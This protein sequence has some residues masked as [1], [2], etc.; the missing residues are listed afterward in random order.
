MFKSHSGKTIHTLFISDL[1]SGTFT[2]LEPTLPG[3]QPL[4]L[5]V[6]PQPLLCPLQRFFSQ[7]RNWRLLQFSRCCHI[8]QHCSTLSVKALETNL[9]SW[10]KCESSFN[11]YRS[12]YYMI[13]SFPTPSTTEMM[14]NPISKID[15]WVSVFA[16]YLRMPEESDI[17]TT[18]SVLQFK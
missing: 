9:D 11:V 15:G 1:R 16:R 5:Q 14:G 13:R 10:E 18:V 2:K 3:S 12:S 7:T 8:W 4:H 6:P 17:G